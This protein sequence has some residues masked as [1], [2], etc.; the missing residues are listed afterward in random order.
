M[1]TII[2]NPNAVQG[3]PFK[4]DGIEPNDAILPNTVLDLNRASHLTVTIKGDKQLLTCKECNVGSVPL[5]FDLDEKIVVSPR[6]PGNSVGVIALEFS[7]PVF[8]A[9]VRIGVA[10][11][12]ALRPFRG[13]I[14]AIETSGRER[15]NSFQ[16]VSTNNPDNSA[17]F[18]GAISAGPA[19]CLKRLEFDAEVIMGEQTFRRFAIS[20]LIYRVA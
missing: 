1:L 13:I 17:L 9:G 6:K 12:N 15:F 2:T 19:A 14:R 18:L 16:T 4:W 7:S 20:S 3:I 8:A 5:N 11:K 10:G